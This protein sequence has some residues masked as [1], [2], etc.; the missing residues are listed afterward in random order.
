MLSEIRATAPMPLLLSAVACLLCATAAVMA[1]PSQIT[2]VHATLLRAGARVEEFFTRAQSLV[3]TE[4]V[5][6]Q[7]L[8]SGLSPDGFSRTVESELRIAWAPEDGGRA[9]TEAQTRREV[10]KVNGR[11]PRANDHR[12]CTTPEQTDAE[13]QP[14]SMLLGDQRPRYSFSAAGVQRIDGR[15]A[16]VIEFRELARVATKVSAVEGLDDCVSYDIT[17]GWRGRLWIDRE[18]YDVLRLDQRLGGM[19]EFRLPLVLARRPNSTPYMTVER[20]DTSLRFGRVSFTD[21]DESLVLPVSSSSL[22]VVRGNVSQRLR[23]ITTYSNY[24]RFMTGSRIVG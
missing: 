11:P 22:R 15:Q 18:T 20:E 6:M 3:C 17:G 4:T 13:R 9:V 1:A 21:P 5:I 2:D 10:I 14:L 19:V 23:T 24:K 8:G 12:S 7:P 16:L